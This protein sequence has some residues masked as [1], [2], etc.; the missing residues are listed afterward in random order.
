[1][2]IKKEKRL[3]MENKKVIAVYGGSF[4]PPLNSHF[5][6]AE[7]IINEYEN[8]EKVILLPVNQKYAKPGL[9][10]NEHRYN[11]LKLVCD[12]NDDFILS[13]MELIQDEQLETLETLN[14]LQK[15][16]P[17]NK[18]C[19]TIGTDNLKEIFTWPTY[20]ELV[21]NYDILV[22]ERGED[23]MDEIINSHEELIK[24]KDSFIKLKENIRSNI[25]STFVREKIRRGKSIRYLTPDEVYYYIKENNLY[26]EFNN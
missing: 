18:L 15:E 21:K 17:E 13:D 3:Y 12:K 26:N 7:Q 11:M 4:N 6:L 2:Q 23:D 5:S 1:M 10:E 22:L 16:Y 19:F 24:H 20:E 25:S 14:L 8:I 9:V